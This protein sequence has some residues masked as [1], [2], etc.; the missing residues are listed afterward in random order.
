MFD[1][2]LGAP[3]GINKIYSNSPEIEYAERTSSPPHFWLKYARF[4]TVLQNLTAVE[5]LK[6]AATHH[7]TTLF[8]LHL[9]Y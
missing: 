1:V 2:S 5:R 8:V 7:S 4:R 6:L 3:G 9:G